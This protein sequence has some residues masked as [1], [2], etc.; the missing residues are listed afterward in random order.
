MNVL[1]A[2]LTAATP[3]QRARLAKEARTTAGTLHQLAGGFRTDGELRASPELAKR[4]EIASR[5]VKNHW[6]NAPEPLRRE[7][8][9]P[10]CGACEFAK[11]CRK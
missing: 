10:A 7:D 11:Q 1:K 9:C 3:A 5:R 2:W 4:L 6:R 8:L